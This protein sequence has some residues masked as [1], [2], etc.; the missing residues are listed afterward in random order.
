MTLCLFRGLEKQYGAAHCHSSFC[1]LCLAFP[2]PCSVSKQRNKRAKVSKRLV[3]VN[4]KLIHS[5]ISCSG[6]KHL[7]RATL[8]T[9]DT[10]LSV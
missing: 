1:T 3:S 6:G 8:S 10:F 5:E 7:S 2:T 4:A 9:N